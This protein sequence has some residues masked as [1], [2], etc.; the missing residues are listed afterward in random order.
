MNDITLVKAAE[1]EAGRKE[2]V[3]IWRRM[4]AKCAL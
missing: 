2:A 3:E 1:W 4:E